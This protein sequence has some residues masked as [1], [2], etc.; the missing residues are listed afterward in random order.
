[1]RLCQEAEF[2]GTRT[3]SPPLLGNCESVVKSHVKE[4]S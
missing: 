4:D 1:M 2:T 3:E